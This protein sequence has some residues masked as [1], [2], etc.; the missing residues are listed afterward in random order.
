MGMAATQARLLSLTNRKNT[1]G[2]DLSRLSA[3][4]MSLARE[5]DAIS[6]RYTEALN[7]KT[8]KWSNDSGATYYDLT[9][10]TLMS[11]SA[12]NN[13]EP[14]MFTDMNGKVVVDDTYKKY[15]EMISP[16]GAPG[17]DYDSH[18]TEILSALTGISAE[19]FEK[20]ESDNEDLKY[21]EKEIAEHLASELEILTTTA[22]AAFQ[23]LGSVCGD[24][25]S[26]TTGGI[27]SGATAVTSGTSWTDI[28]N[29]IGGGVNY[30][31]YLYND[32]H[33]VSDDTANDKFKNILTE[34]GNAIASV[35]SSVEITDSSIDSAI[36]Q[37]LDLFVQHQDSTVA[38]SDAWPNTGNS[39]PNCNTIV[40]VHDK[41]TGLFGKS[42]ETY[43]VSLTNM[44]SVFLTY[45]LGDEEAQSKI[46]TSSAPGID[47]NTITLTDAATQAEHDE[48]QTTYDELLAQQSE[49]Q[50]SASTIFDAEDEKLIDFYDA[51]FENIATNGWTY[52]EYIGDTD[53]LNNVL[54]NGMYN[55][56]K[57][58][59]GEDGSW[60]YDESAPTTCQNVYQV[61][62]SSAENKATAEYELEKTRLQRKEE[63]IDTRMQKLETEQNAIN[64]M[65]DAYRSMIDDNVERT[66]DVFS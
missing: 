26:S 64:E 34:L 59:K 36:Q 21:L 65:L 40:H 52:N 50:E 47:L 48:W 9:Y 61:S 51:I 6:T 62:D 44:A 22:D 56:T 18:R 66:F 45:L 38:H 11:P 16:N 8:L 54:Q 42:H 15:A 63:E 10:N 30:I 33:G 20:Q 25:C 53:Y 29:S 32:K 28:I 13:Y 27:P 17:G 31:T 3:Q 41:A 4:K 37:T 23:Q 2:Y 39:A 19:D 1:I 12:L 60:E 55:I 58:E 14:Y 49:L 5:S 57:A 35:T 7:E 46:T 24:A 43:A